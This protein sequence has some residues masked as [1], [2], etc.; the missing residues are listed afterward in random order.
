MINVV[1]IAIA[2]NLM[3][4]DAPRAPPVPTPPRRLLALTRAETAAVIGALRAPL[5]NL[6]SAEPR[7]KKKKLCEKK[8]PRGAEKEKVFFFF[9]PLLDASSPFCSLPRFT[10]LSLAFC[11]FLSLSISLARSSAGDSLSLSLLTK[12]TLKTRKKIN[13]NKEEKLS[14]S[15]SS[16]PPGP[17]EHHR[18][19]DHDQRD[20][21]GP[22][23]PPLPRL[24]RH[25]LLC[26]CAYPCLTPCSTA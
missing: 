15:L 19:R 4:D 21:H 10:C 26:T 25:L 18:H 1:A 2:A 5:M 13:N 23:Q 8:K 9:L 24:L 6:G 11:F 14:L 16:K 3:V 22:R 17:L 20:H 7:K 12:K